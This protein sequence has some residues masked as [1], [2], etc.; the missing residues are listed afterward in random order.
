MSVQVSYVHLSVSDFDMSP[1]NLERLSQHSLLGYTPRVPI[2]EIWGEAW[3]F[4]F[5]TS[6]Q[7][8]LLLLVQGPHFAN[9]FGQHRERPQKISVLI[10]AFSALSFFLGG[11]GVLNTEK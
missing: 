6:R 11:G 4:A 8:M 3:E 1:H 2:R 5:L 9:H 10:T 7:L